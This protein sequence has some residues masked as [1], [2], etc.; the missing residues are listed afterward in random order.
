MISFLLIVAG[1][2]ESMA[3]VTVVA[4]FGMKVD[5]ALRSLHLTRRD[6]G[7]MARVEVSHL[8]LIATVA[9]IRRA[10]LPKHSCMRM[11][12][13]YQRV[14][15]AVYEREFTAKMRDVPGTRSA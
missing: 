3:V 8:T 14:V 2:P 1:N 15:L 9:C 7:K 6:P 12:F 13:D 10:S 5:K 11:L 4:E